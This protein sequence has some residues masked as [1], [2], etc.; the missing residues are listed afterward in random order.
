VYQINSKSSLKAA[1]LLGAATATAISLSAPAAADTPVETVVV[2]CSLIPTPNATSNSPIQT[3]GTEQIDLSGH[4]NIEQVLNQMPQ[5]APSQGS[6]SNNPGVGIATVDLHGLTPIRTLVLIDGER[7]MPSIIFPTEFVDIAT[8]PSSLIDHVDIVSGGGSATYGSDAI[9][10]VVNFVL[11]KD[12][13]GFQTQARWGQDMVNS[14]GAQTDINVILGINSGDGKANV[15]I[16]GEFYKRA[17]VLQGE[18]PDYAID[19][20]GGSGTTPNGV[21]AGTQGFPTIASAGCGGHTSAHGKYSFL[22]NGNPVEYCNKLPTSSGSAAA[23]AAASQFETLEPGGDRYSFAAVNFLQTPETRH[24][25]AATGHY[26]IFPD[27]EAFANFKYTNTLVDI[28]LAPTPITAGV[29]LNFQATPNAAAATCPG[30]NCGSDPGSA[31]FGVP[32]TTSYIS[33]AFQQEINARAITIN[34]NTKAPYGYSPFTVAWRSAQVGARLDQFT[35]DVYDGT[36]GFQGNLPWFQGWDYKAYYQQGGGLQDSAAQNNILASHLGQAMLSCPAGSGTG[37]VPIDIFGDN[38]LSPDMINFIR[39]RTNDVNTFE[40]ELFHANTEGNIGDFWG[41]GQIAMAFGMEWRKD[42]GTF[43]PDQAKQNFDILG[44]NPSRATNGNFNVWELFN[45]T[46]IPLVTNVPFIE[47][48]DLDGGFRFSRYSGAGDLETWKGGA[49]YQ[50]IDDIRFRVM[51]QRAARAPNVN[52]LFNGGSDGFPVIHDPCDHDAPGGPPVAACTN[53]FAAAGLTYH[54]ATYEQ[55]NGQEEALAFGNPHLKPEKSNTFTVGAVLTPT[56]LP[57][58]TAS[59]DYFHIAVS[60]FIGA[61]FGGAPNVE[62]T[63]INS[64]NGTGTRA[65]QELDPNF[66]NACDLVSRTGAGDLIF[67]IPGENVNLGDLKT[68]GIDVQFNAQHDVADLLGQSGDWGAVDA[69]IAIEFINEYQDPVE[70][71]IKGHVNVSGIAGDIGANPIPAYKMTNTFG[72]TFGD[73]RVMLTW[74]EIDGVSDNEGSGLNIPTYDLFDLAIR[75]NITDQ[76]AA[77]IIVNNLF[78]KTAPLG[79]FGNNDGGINTL[80]NTYD[81]LGTEVFLGL[82]AKL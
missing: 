29:A 73:W 58:V 49:D 42:T 27:V 23:V 81:V 61:A 47:S 22:P 2:T 12:F 64:D 54:S 37:C 45:E 31:F 74:E 17:G 44:F 13:Q 55:T 56:F 3:L 46:R 20:S 30:V 50:P 21:V 70:G 52:E 53:Q 75:W 66:G 39:A 1:L 36:V 67:S 28:Q 72:Y 34:P 69:N 18:N 38:N 82:T 48:L 63:C 78:N 71:N 35:N 60:N 32:G 15:T 5:I 16:Y 51:W 65:F 79:P 40:R 77:D 68:G 43:T 26:D 57:G 24:E 33:P 10:G 19:F 62:T 9:A 7:A 4:A 6:N 80:N 25:L 14:Y 59:V 41:A 8:I 11:K 76:Y